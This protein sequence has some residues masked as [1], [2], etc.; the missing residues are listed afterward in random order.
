VTDN[1]DSDDFATASTAVNAL[2]PAALNVDTLALSQTTAAPARRALLAHLNAGQLLVNYMGHGSV[3]VWASEELL[4]AADAQ[5]LTNGP[6]LPVVVAMTCLNGFFH[7][8]ATTSLAEALLTAE[9]GGAVAVWASSGLTTPAGQAV[10][11]QELVRQLFGAE[12]LTLGEAMVRAKAAVGD[13]DVRRTWILFGDPTLR[14][15]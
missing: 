2:L 7:D 15:E 1:H 8:L 10:L 14:L 5:A 9:H 6:R 12:R 4:T 13:R 11:N 3:A